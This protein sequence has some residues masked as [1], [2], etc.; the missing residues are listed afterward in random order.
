MSHWDLLYLVYFFVDPFTILPVSKL[1]VTNMGVGPM[2]NNTLKCQIQPKQFSLA[3]FNNLF[4]KKSSEA[5][6]TVNPDMDKRIED[7]NKGETEK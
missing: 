5:V 1:V 7:K 2:R 6:T 3:V 4:R